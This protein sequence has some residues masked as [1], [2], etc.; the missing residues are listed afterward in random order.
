MSSN[1][2]SAS[3]MEKHANPGDETSPAQPPGRQIRGIRVS[4]ASLPFRQ[5]GPFLTVPPPQWILVLC[6]IYSSMFIYSLDNTITADL[7]PAIANEYN[8]V[9]MLPWLSVGFMAGAY[10]GILPMGKLYAKFDAKW[11][12]TVNTVLFLGASA[13][14]GAAPDMNSMIVGRVWLGVAG[15]AMYC[16]IMTLITISTDAH[17]KPKYFSITGVVWSVGTVLGPVVGGAF[18]TFDWRWAF[19]INLIIG[20]IFM[21]I[22][23]FVLPSFDPLPKS[24]T[25]RQRLYKFDF[26]GTILLAGFSICLVMAIN[27]GG[28]LY[29][30][31]SGSTVA[32]FV[33]GGV[34]FLVFV[35]QQHFSWLTTL[36]DRL[37]PAA[38]LKHKESALL[39]I[40]TICSNTAAFI[41]IY[42]IPVYFQFSKGDSA[43]DAAVRLLPLII[44][45]SFANLAQGLLLVKVGYYWPWFVAGGALSLAG[46][47]MLYCIDAGTSSGYIYGAE[48][49]L[50]LGL[51]FC[52]QTPYGVIHGVIPP[53][54]AGLGVPSVL[55]LATVSLISDDFRFIMIA[56]YTGI[57]AALSVSGAVFVNEGLS[58]LHR[59]LPDLPLDD[60]NGILS[61]ES[62]HCL[63][64]ETVRL[65]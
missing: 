38:L 3:D 63:L 61:G 44:V 26:L 37:F 4:I 11:V 45:F 19:Y 13:L 64:Q 56:Q 33:V 18:A 21:P 52:N 36:S 35:A 15:S 39:F 8:S 50:A 59:L 12:Y 32:L 31:N 55:H 40:S 17:E 1:S 2:Q 27:F 29:A 7:V 6:A 30:W 23:L 57:T 43:L 34:G 24:V 53:H 10:V 49:I 9:A 28:V 58:G 48:V 16:G 60:L 54:E 62:A 51:G 25:R 5:P 42:Y 20:G 65:T 46:N 47:V 14:C 41:P 22:Y